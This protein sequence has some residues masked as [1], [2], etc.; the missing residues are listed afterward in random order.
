MDLYRI[1]EGLLGL[2]QKFDD[3]K[4]RMEKYFFLFKS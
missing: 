4:V 3:G 1:I 2:A